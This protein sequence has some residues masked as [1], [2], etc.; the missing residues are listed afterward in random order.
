M[1]RV[2]LI[3][4]VVISVITLVILLENTEPVQASILFNPVSISLALLMVL[5]FILGFTVGI[6][7][8]TYFVRKRGT[9]A[10]PDAGSGR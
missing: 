8:A 4:I 6:L 2:K 1:W 5:T 3:A 7:T 10:R 9:K